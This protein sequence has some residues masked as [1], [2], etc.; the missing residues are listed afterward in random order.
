MKIIDADAFDAVL[1]DAQ[2]RAKSNFQ[3]GFL[4]SVRA[5]LKEMPEAEAYIEQRKRIENMEKVIEDL[6]K[7]IAIISEGGWH[8]TAEEKPKLKTD[9][10]FESITVIC[11]DKDSK[12]ERTYPLKWCRRKVRGNI[13]YRWEFMYDNI[14]YN[15][16]YYWQY[17]PEPP[18]EGEAE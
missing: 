7:R 6:E 15:E 1:V 16:P 9:F 10:P 13:V 4:S 17:L 3:F 8:K 14:C 18:K 12:H 2:K 11:A 5:N